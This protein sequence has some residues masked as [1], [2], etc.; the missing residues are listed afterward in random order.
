MSCKMYVI[1][2]FYSKK[3]GK[4]YQNYL[5]NK[6]AFQNPENLQSIFGFQSKM[7]ITLFFYSKTAKDIKII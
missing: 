4:R 1:L 3:N 6:K 2:Y 7:Q 5:S